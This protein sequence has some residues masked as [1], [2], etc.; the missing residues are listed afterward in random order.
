MR[1]SEFMLGGEDFKDLKASQL[2]EADVV[3]CRPE[4]TWRQ[5]T[6]L[7]SHGGFGDVPIIDK[8]KTLLGIV[9]EFDLLKVLM[10]GKDVK[11]ITAGD[12]MTTNVV[13]VS[14]VTNSVEIV[15]ILETKH[16][17][18]VPVVRNGRLVGIVARRDVLFSF[19][20]ASTKPPGGLF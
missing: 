7:M 2:M 10:E 13:S 3:A 6:D 11:N 14:E 12:I 5:M 16:L 20:Q 15:N 17:I 4:N 9:T 1:R 8:D 18:R 19:I